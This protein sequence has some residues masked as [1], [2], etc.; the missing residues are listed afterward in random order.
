MKK[1]TAVTIVLG[2]AIGLAGNVWGAEAGTSWRVLRADTSFGA[3]SD[4]K[5]TDENGVIKLDAPE[6]EE[7][8]ASF[9][10]AGVSLKDA[11]EVDGLTLVVRPQLFNAGANGT[12]NGWMGIT[13]T[14]SAPT[15]FNVCTWSNGDTY[16]PV[17][18][19]AGQS[20]V[21]LFGFYN[22]SVGDG[23]SVVTDGADGRKLEYTDTFAGGKDVTVSFRIVE[24]K[25]EVSA[26]GRVICTSAADG[27]LTDGKAY[28]SL[29]SVGYDY[30]GNTTPFEIKT[31]NG[32]AA[33]TYHEDEQPSS[34]I[35]SD[36]SA[37][38]SAV[39]PSAVTSSVSLGGCA[40]RAV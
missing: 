20:E 10:Q 27:I 9:N 19:T 15:A 34:D 32:K 3:T 8:E 33:S 38:S 13:L 35:S 4:G 7:G 25:I 17:E 37:S 36:S 28:L 26:D 21:F 12:P 14:K 22:N 5:V 39:I 1:I 40:N 24:N 31:I 23:L 11:V 30:A 2:I 6:G 16:A 29:A 18:V